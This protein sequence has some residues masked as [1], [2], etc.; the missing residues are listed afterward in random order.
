M[1]EEEHPFRVR[2]GRIRSKPS[3]PFRP[4][5]SRVMEAAGKAGG[6]FGSERSGAGRGGVGRGR[7]ASLNARRA[8]IR[9][10]R[11]AV[12][13]AQVVRQGPG[14]TP[15][16]AHLSY[17][18]RDGASREGTPGAMFDAR[19]DQADARDFAE[20]C[21]GDRHHFRFIVSPDDAAELSDLKAYTRDLMA[22]AEQDLGTSLDWVA[23]DHWNTA[24]PHIH[25]LVRGRT[26]QSEDLV[27]SRDYI[28]QGLRDR[29]GR[30]VTLEL[31][32]RSD[33]EVRRRLEAEIEAERWTPLDRTISRDA[34]A[35]R[36]VDFRP[37]MA[38]DKDEFSTFKI[39]RLQKLADLGLAEPLGPA[40]W[41]LAED[42]E[43]RL[44]QLGQRG[45]VIARLHQALGA[46][47]QAGDYVL[48]SA[49]LRRPVLGRLAARGLDDELKGSAY[50]VIDGVDGRAHHVRLPSLDVAGDSGVGAVVEARWTEPKDGRR[51][52][53]VI[54]VRSDLELQAQV[55]APGATWLDRQLVARTPTPLAERG[56]GRE[57][58]AALERRIDHL[59]VE[60][61][62]RRDG[63]RVR[64]APNLIE[65]LRRRELQAVGDRI[66]KETGL[67]PRGVVEGEYVSGVVRRRLTLA[68]GRFAMIDDGM[69]F[70]LVP[71]K[72]ELE[73]HLGRHLTGVA[74]PGGGVD[75]ELGR[76]RGRG[77]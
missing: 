31:G 15:L 44:R 20:R 16:S 6:R 49:S 19:G 59:A 37:P 5:V 30:L 63:D 56:F 23:V 28:S 74:L 54:A 10:S 64:L 58:A 73:R 25:L 3:N 4:F 46:E 77:L 68:S 72:P 17:L 40:Q 39:A 9:R 65:G 76:G 7:A 60:G 53:L 43:V 8:P 67:E 12:V 61:L 2:P 70:S 55:S 13:K 52:V 33:L 45:D 11:G 62:A 69:G 14:R 38:G 22:Q 18:Q 29:A 66:A 50:V 32:P 57:V 21:E 48:D 27:I 75:W 71:W 51:S 34:D 1:T 24:H 47:R 41:R 35:S 42:L 26:D 36:A